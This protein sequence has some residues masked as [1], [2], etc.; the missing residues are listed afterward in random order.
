MELTRLDVSG[1]PG[2]NGYCDEDAYRSIL[3]HMDAEGITPFGVRFLGNGNYHYLS[4]LVTEKIAEPYTLVLF[5]HHPDMR[6]PAFGEI[7]SCGG[8]VR[9]ALR[10]QK[11]LMRVVMA[12]VDETLYSEEHA[13]TP[14]ARLSLCTELSVTGILS[15]IPEAYPVF[16]SIDKD[17]LAEDEIKT[18]WD[19]GEMSL[20]TLL[21]L[22]TAIRENRRVIGAD[23][24]GEPAGNALDRA[25]CPSCVFGSAR[26]E[27]HGDRS[28]AVDLAIVNALRISSR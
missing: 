28:R 13:M 11:H 7:L 1:I 20:R 21:T 24:C 16:L 6:A 19:Q 3:K 15:A 23:L 27:T 22:V 17:V 10:K 18:N 4:Y 25:V 9:D 12:G 8:W 2:T 5:D 14:D 26:D